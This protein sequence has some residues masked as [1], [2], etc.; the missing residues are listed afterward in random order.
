MNRSFIQSLI[1]QS[2]SDPSAAATRLFAL[3]L[4]R[5]V[6]WSAF[7]LIIVLNVLVAILLTPAPPEMAGQPAELQQIM[8]MLNAPLLMT[9]VS[10]GVFVVLIFLLTWVGR[11]IGGSGDLGDMLATLTWVQFLTLLSRFI[12]IALIYVAPGLAQLALFAIWGLSLWITLHFIKVAHRFDHIGQ[13]LATL[14]ITIFGVAFGAAVFLSV[15]GSL[16]KGFAG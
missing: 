2:L 3:K 15:I 4:S 11:V 10:G 9:M 5:D 7:A 12:L 14:L 6:L 16:F 13:S 8:R 1:K